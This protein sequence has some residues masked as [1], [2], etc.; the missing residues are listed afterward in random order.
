MYNGCT[1]RDL[2]VRGDTLAEGIA[3]R[4]PGDA[5]RAAS[6]ARYVDD[7]MLVSEAHIERAVTS[8]CNIEKTVV[9]GAGAAGLAAVIADPLRFA[10][11]KV[12]LVLTGGNIDARLL[13][14]VLTRELARAGRMSR[15]TLDI[16]DRPGELAR[17][18]GVIGAERRQHRRGLSPARLHGSARQGHRAQSRHRDARPRSSRGR[19]RE[20]EEA[21]YEVLAKGNATDRT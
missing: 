9:E 11:R 20:A 5:H 6:C 18:A 21:G 10:G 12:G 2:P 17:V 14:S 1:A 13:A 4:D 7:I 16:P 15:L 8:C 3:V 19:A